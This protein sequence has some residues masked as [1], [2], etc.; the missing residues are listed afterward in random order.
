MR[1]NLEAFQGKC[2]KDKYFEG[3]YYKVS[4]GNYSFVI[5]AGISLGDKKEGYIRILDNSRFNRYYSFPIEQCNID[6]GNCYLKINNCIF[7][8][9]RIAIDIE[10]FPQIKAD[11]IFT[12]IIKYPR[13]I[14]QNGIMGIYNNLPF[15][16]CKH[17][18][19]NM[20]YNTRGSI[21]FNRIA[22]NLDG[23]VGYFEK[24]WG[25]AFPEKWIW[26]EA[27]RFGGD[28]T[29]KV[30]V[31]KMQF[32]K[33][34]FFCISSCVYTGGEFYNVSTYNGAKL[35]EC[36]KKSIVIKNKKY[37]LMVKVL[38]SN[39]GLKLQ[40]PFEEYLDKGVEEDINAKIM[41]TL[42]DEKTDKVIYKGSSR[43][44]GMQWSEGWIPE[45]L[46]DKQKDRHIE[47]LNKA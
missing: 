39:Y 17:E 22:I 16:D 15:I 42:T 38:G 35:Q 27:D 20:R 11:I 6:W 45:I 13:K 46:T 23:G 9:S 2:K 36:D 18:I 25:K 31:A 8:D 10:D 5:I 1:K 3:W 29:L 28:T 30:A 21:M 44:G 34:E 41:I 19:I 7:S 26:L 24:N 14:L 32:F 47:I 4:C 37:T 12:N 43:F 40:A 33:K